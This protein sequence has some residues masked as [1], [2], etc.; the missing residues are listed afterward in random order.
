M[1]GYGFYRTQGGGGEG[2]GFPGGGEGV[3]RKQREQ[4]VYLSRCSSKC[5]CKAFL[6]LG[7]GV[8]LERG[9]RLL[10]CSSLA[11]ADCSRVCNTAAASP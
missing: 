11:V 2:G 5:L 1:K 4:R 7:R 8:D 10:S 9:F 3:G 6:D